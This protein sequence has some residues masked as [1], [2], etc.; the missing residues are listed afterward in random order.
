[1]T[2]TV[3]D[4]EKPDIPAPASVT[5]EA[6]GQ[7]TVVNLTA[8]TATDNVGV[9]YLDDDAPATFGLGETTV[10]WTA[11]DAAGN[12]GS[13]TQTVTIE[14][15]TAPVITGPDNVTKEATGTDTIVVQEKVNRAC[16]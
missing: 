15:T 3:E 11:R 5:K 16:I 6:T 8:P 13:A 1:M 14:D 12:V 10:T 9:V 7:Q 4:N 2:V